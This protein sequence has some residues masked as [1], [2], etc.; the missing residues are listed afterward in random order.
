[1]R[2]SLRSS[3][4]EKRCAL[5]SQRGAAALAMR[6]PLA[7]PSAFL[8]FLSIIAVARFA[9]RRAAPLCRKKLPSGMLWRWPELL[10]A[11]PATMQGG[12][13]RR[14]APLFSEKRC[15]LS[16][17]AWRCCSSHSIASLLSA[18]ALAGSTPAR[19]PA[20]WLPRPPL[21]WQAQPPTEH[22]LNV[23]NLRVKGLTPFA[24][25]RSMIAAF[26]F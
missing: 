8:R 6:A 9:R 13:A 16:S 15:A 19:F 11:P 22:H 3:L 26:A 10:S 12:R 24:R 1:M 23:A 20:P 25:S 18:I 14:C 7:A 17:P 4:L 5:S 2:S 21:A